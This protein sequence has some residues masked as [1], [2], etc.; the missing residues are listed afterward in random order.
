MSSCPNASAGPT[1]AAA[2]IAR[3]ARSNMASRHANR[4]VPLGGG[5]GDEPS[6]FWWPRI[7]RARR[8]R[9][10]PSR[11]RE[12]G[13]SAEDELVHPLH[14]LAVRPPPPP[15]A[16]EEPGDHEE[17]RALGRDG[18]RSQLPQEPVRLVPQARQASAPRGELPLR[19]P[20]AGALPPPLG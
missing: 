19:L 17:V 12:I 11:M 2:G 6:M 13:T 15:Q 8:I 9:R 1:G 10:D 3:A 7:P 5:L 14:E 16:L 4:I 20:L 18:H